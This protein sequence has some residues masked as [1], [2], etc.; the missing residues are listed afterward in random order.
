MFLDLQLLVSGIFLTFVVKIITVKLNIIRP[1]DLN[2][3]A[4]IFF[5]HEHH[6]DQTKQFVREQLNASRRHGI[7]LPRGV[8]IS[9]TLLDSLVVQAEST[10]PHDVSSFFVSFCNFL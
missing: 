6:R 8:D 3:F 1:A 4:V 9:T 7:N 5:G 2:S 10:N